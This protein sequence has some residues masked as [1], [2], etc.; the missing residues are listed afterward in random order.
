M[1]QTPYPER[2]AQV[3][4]AVPFLLQFQIIYIVLRPLLL[5]E[6]SSDLFLSQD[7]VL[8]RILLAL[9]VLRVVVDVGWEEELFCKRQRHGSSSEWMMCEAGNYLGSSQSLGLA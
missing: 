8:H 7:D 6:H 5:R 1:K 4:P 9:E 3:K 2:A